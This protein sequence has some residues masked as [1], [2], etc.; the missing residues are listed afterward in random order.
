MYLTLNKVKLILE[1]YKNFW[2]SSNLI[3]LGCLLMLFYYGKIAF[4]NFFWIKILTLGVIVYFINNFKKEHFYFYK[5]LGINKIP[6]W[7][8]VI[9]LDLLILLIPFLIIIYFL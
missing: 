5:N 2:F 1:F 3:N 6:L 8:S 4:S 9:T 7:I